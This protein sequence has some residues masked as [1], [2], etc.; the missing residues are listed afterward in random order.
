[1]KT[2]KFIIAI[3]LLIGFTGCQQ[4]FDAQ[5]WAITVDGTYPHREKML[6]DL[7]ENYPLKDKTVQETV[8]LLGLPD[9]YCDHNPYEM[10]YRIVQ[11]YG[12]NIDPVYT[13]YL[14]LQLDDSSNPVDSN[15]LIVGFKIVELDY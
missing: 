13:K 5:K 10:T 14:H 12:W 11:D 7:L 3:T 2:F 15:T 1:M 4:K 8:E 6:D 9:N